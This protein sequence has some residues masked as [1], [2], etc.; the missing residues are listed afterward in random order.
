MLLIGGNMEFNFTAK[1]FFEFIRENGVCK[2]GIPTREIWSNRTNRRE[3]ARDADFAELAQG[4][5]INIEILDEYD[6]RTYQSIYV[7]NCSF[8]ASDK[9][10]FGGKDSNRDFS[11]A[12]CEYL[13]E[14]Y[15]EEYSRETA[16]ALNEDI[17]KTDKLMDNPN[18]APDKKEKFSLYKKFFTK[19][20]EI[21][22]NKQKE[23]NQKKTEWI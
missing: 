14:K 13:V 1:D 10:A 23:L 15:G 8:I 19:F 2:N 11:Q 20:K 9:T 17:K 18:V 5:N 21:I 7:S 4:G 22:V 3:P 6:D 16:K 12:W